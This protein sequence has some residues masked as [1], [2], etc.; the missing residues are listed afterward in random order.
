MFYTR[1]MAGTKDGA[2]GD[3]GERAGIS[4]TKAFSL[5]LLGI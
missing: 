5:S 3:C 2:F 4:D 1:G